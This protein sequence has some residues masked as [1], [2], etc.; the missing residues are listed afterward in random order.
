MSIREGESGTRMLITAY[1][2]LK[3][4][5]FKLRQALVKIERLTRNAECVMHIH[6]IAIEALN[7]DKPPQPRDKYGQFVPRNL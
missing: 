6:R 2:R 5:K 4:K 3:E 1:G 7:Q